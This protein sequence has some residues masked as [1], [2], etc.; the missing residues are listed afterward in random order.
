[1]SDDERYDRQRRIPGWDQNRLAAATVLVVGAGAIG[2]EVLKN[3]ALAGVGH[4]VIVDLDRV[5]RSNL[6]RTLLFRTADCGMPKAEAAAHALTALNPAVQVTPLVG[7]LRFVLGLGRV[8]ACTLAVGCLDNQGARSFLSRMCLLAGV[9]LL[10]GAMWAMG[11]EVRTF[12]AAEGPCFD[13]TLTP[14]ER[15]DLWLRFSCS[16]GFQVHEAPAVAPTLITTTAIVGGLLA[17]A[18]LSVLQGL[19]VEN[20]SAL[21]YNGQ[22]GRL[23]RATLRRDP[24][25]PN[26]HPLDWAQITPLPGSVTELTAAALLDHAQHDCHADLT[27]DLGRDLLLSFAC[28][29]CGAVEAVGRPQ[30]LLAASAACCPQC[31]SERRPHVVA[32]VQRAD[33]WAAWSLAQLGI[34]PGD[35]VSVRS[36][37]QVLMYVGEWGMRNEE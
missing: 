34:Q 9:P 17:Q 2:N 26:H 28:P 13:C 12:L 15:R 36:S 24:A 32:T 25:C 5:E 27:L 30:G 22:T 11:G 10:D 37:E 16:G 3:L 14:D 29:G 21:V 4:L 8:H 31:G 20:G 1:M 19:S 35:V 7:D 6:S 18:A 23:H 33:A